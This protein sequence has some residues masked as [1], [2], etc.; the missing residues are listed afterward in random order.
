MRVATRRARSA[1]K[2]FGRA[3]DREATDP[4]GQELKWLAA[5]LGLE[6]DR[7]VLAERLA[8]R[9]AELDPELVGKP[10]RRRLRAPDTTGPSPHTA[11]LHELD[12]A[13]YFALLDALEALVAA[14]PYLRPAADAPAE[15]G[16]A[17]A[18]R[19]DHARLRAAVENALS[20]PPGEERDIALHDARKD[21]KRVRY[22]S[23]AATPVLGDRATAHT[24]RMKRVQQ[25]LGEHQD[26]C[27]ARDALIALRAAALAAGEDPAPYDAMV[28]RERDLAAT[29]ESDLPA[30]WESADQPL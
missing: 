6:R 11:L 5:V 14:P 9:L 7:E 24:T 17:A 26:S 19:R 23:E 13:R 3:L 12:G 16:A 20:L 29:V 21:A 18:V 30:A 15:D 25:L 10:L 27:I 22:S 2:S 28:R 4:I 8:R 1:L